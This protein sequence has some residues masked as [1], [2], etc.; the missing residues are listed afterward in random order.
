MLEHWAFR[1][2]KT[3]TRILAFLVIALAVA[4]C[5]AGCAPRAYPLAGHPGWTL[6]ESAIPLSGFPDDATTQEA[7]ECGTHRPWPKDQKGPPLPPCGM[8]DA[9]TS[10]SE[11]VVRVWWYA[12]PGALDHEL[13]HVAACP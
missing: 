12:R 4:W 5:S 13:T 10:C 8:T 2:M 11:R 7:A 6:Q 9:T 3:G 1:T